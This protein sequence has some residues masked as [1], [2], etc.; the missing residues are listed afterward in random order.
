MPSL[1]LSGASLAAF[2][3]SA[4]PQEP[5]TAARV[6][7]HVE[8]VT[9]GSSLSLAQLRDLSA[10]SGRIPRHTPLGFYAAD[11]RD[12][13]TI[14]VGNERNDV[15]L[16]PVGVQVAVQLTNRHIQVATD[17]KADACRYDIAV[18]H[19]QRHAD[20]DAAVVTRFIPILTETFARA[21]LPSLVSAIGRTSPDNAEI[22]IAMKRIADPVLGEMGI[23]QRS[24]IEAI[25]TPE[26]ISLLETSCGSGT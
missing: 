15:C 25:D 11:T 16:G 8:D 19:Y 12:T 6:V 7:A 1:L 21:P 18:A 9:V 22:V 23:A 14:T 24:A 10:R 20:A 5:P 26:E 13:T 3:V 2:L 17:L 4:C